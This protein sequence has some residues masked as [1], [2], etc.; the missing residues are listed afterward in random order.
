MAVL[1]NLLLG[2]KAVVN[3]NRDL[4]EFNVPVAAEFVPA[5]LYGPGY[6]VGT[7]RGLVSSLPFLPPL[8]LQRQPAQ[9]GSLTG[10]RSGS[11]DGI[12]RI[13]GVPQIGEH[14]DAARFDLGGLRVLVLVDHVLV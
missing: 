12:G 6:Q 13:G 14:V 3:L 4:A 11:T 9:H 7:V 5:H 8:P 2:D 1:G 10:T